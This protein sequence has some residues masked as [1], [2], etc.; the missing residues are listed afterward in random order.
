MDATPDPSMEE[1]R[2]CPIFTQL[3]V[4]TTVVLRGTVTRGASAAAT[5]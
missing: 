4:A 5:A 2:R 1:G 3:V